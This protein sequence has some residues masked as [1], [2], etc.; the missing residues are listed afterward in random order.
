MPFSWKNQFNGEPDWSGRVMMIHY[1]DD[2]NW[3]QPELAV[4]IN[5]TPY[6]TDFTLPEGRDWS[7]ILDT[8]AELDLDGTRNEPQ[9]YFNTNPDADRRATANI[10]TQNPVEVGNTYLLP[11]FSIAILEEK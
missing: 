11:P 9:G 8:R 7:R 3:N 5:M 10:T 4:L 1:Y 2:G 6:D